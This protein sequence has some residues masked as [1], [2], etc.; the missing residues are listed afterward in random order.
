MSKK[1]ENPG[2]PKDKCAECKKQ[3]GK[4]KCSSSSGHPMGCQ[5]TKCGP[6]LSPW[7]I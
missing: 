2:H 4:C 3:V 6:I 7:D 1:Y 5:C